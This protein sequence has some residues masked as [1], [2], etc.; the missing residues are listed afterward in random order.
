MIAVGITFALF[1]CWSVVGYALTGS[2]LSR[3]DAFSNLLLA[4]V[5]GM[6]TLELAAHIG[7]RCESPVGP[8]SRGIVLTSLLIAIAV[9]AV[10]RP[11]FP[12]RRILPFGLVILA[13]FLLSGWPLLKWGSDWIA[14]ANGAID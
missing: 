12:F 9:L 14:N 11:P 5:V 3:R 1:M 13:A 6:C 7:L 8:I 2:L 10:R 4:P